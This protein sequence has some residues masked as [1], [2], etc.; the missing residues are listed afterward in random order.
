MQ[1]GYDALGFIS[2]TGTNFMV[3]A[4]ALKEVGGRCAHIHVSSLDSSFGFESRLS[5]ARIT[6]ESCWNTYPLVHAA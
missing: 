1:P 5:E 4:A 2:C 3:R 6:Y